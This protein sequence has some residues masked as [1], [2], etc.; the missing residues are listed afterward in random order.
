[1]F[2]DKR[3]VYAAPEL[4]VHGSIEE[5]TQGNAVGKGPLALD[6]N[7]AQPNSKCGTGTDGLGGAECLTS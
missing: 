4:M 5:I 1:M 6:P 3:K 2:S 7:G